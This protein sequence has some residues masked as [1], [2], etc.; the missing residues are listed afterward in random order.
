MVTFCPLLYLVRV[1]NET[2]Y[3]ILTTYLCFKI[4]NQFVRLIFIS[5]YEDLDHDYIIKTIWVYLGVL[6]FSVSIGINYCYSCE[7][8]L[9]F[10]NAD[11]T[12][13]LSSCSLVTVVITQISNLMEGNNNKHS[14]NDTAADAITVLKRVKK[15]QLTSNSADT[16]IFTAKLQDP[17]AFPFVCC[18]QNKLFTDLNA[19]REG[20]NRNVVSVHSPRSC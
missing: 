20:E 12:M 9:R 15:H 1:S 4:F 3:L 2:F 10:A 11:L 18:V 17:L 5:T 16:F 14:C 6:K 19:F 7:R 8:I 13:F